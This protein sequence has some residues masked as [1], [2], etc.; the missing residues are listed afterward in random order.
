LREFSGAKKTEIH[1][2]SFAIVAEQRMLVEE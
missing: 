2:V 1:K